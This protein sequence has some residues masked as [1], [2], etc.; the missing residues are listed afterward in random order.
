MAKILLIDDIPAV[1]H[2]LTAILEKEGHDVT[3]VADGQS[4]LQLATAEGFDL[5][6]TDIMMP[7]S[8]GTDVVFALK[9]SRQQMKVVA[10]SGGGAGISPSEALRLAMVKSDAVLAK[11]IENALLISTVNELLA[12]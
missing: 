2:A 12:A 5:V 6:L 4:G 3:A 7:D 10:M 11:P 9:E 1:R 8:D